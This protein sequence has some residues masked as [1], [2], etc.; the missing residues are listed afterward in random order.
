MKDN[1]FTMIMNSFALI[2]GSCTE[3]LFGQIYHIRQILKE[4]REQNARLFG[5]FHK[6]SGSF[7]HTLSVRNQSITFISGLEMSN[8]HI[9]GLAALRAIYYFSACNHFS[10][11]KKLLAS[12]YSIPIFMVDIHTG[13]MPQYN[14]CRRSQLESD[15]P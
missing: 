6:A 4:S 1:V 9:S 7:F 11:E 14:Y 15:M 2:E 8:P 10:Q 12:P 13:Y 3:R 5:S